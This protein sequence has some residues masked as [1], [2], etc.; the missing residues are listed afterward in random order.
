M[1]PQILLNIFLITSLPA[2]SQTSFMPTEL[3]AEPGEQKSNNLTSGTSSSLRVS[4]SS[5]F[6]TNVSASTSGR[7]TTNS[8]SNLK[9]KSEVFG[10][11]LTPAGSYTSTF[12]GSTI[13]DINIEVTNIRSEGSGIHSGTGSEDGDIFNIN[14]DDALAAEGTASVKGVFNNLEINIDGENTTN[15]VEIDDLKA[16]DMDSEDREENPIDT[17]NSSSGVRMDSSL[18]VDISNNDFNNAFSQAF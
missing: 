9:T 5:S 8:T 16:L 6:G 15:N 17:A 7:F 14:S 2:F 10:D 1:K 13:G 4:T 12:G 3:I 18:N 11:S